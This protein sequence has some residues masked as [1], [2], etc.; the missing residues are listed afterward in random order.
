[1]YHVLCQAQ[2]EVSNRLLVTSEKNEEVIARIGILEHDLRE[3]V[4]RLEYA[5]P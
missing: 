4:S 5:L 3:Q 1:M 2:N